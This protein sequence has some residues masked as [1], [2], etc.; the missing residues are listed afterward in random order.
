MEDEIAWEAID[1]T[2]AIAIW[3][4]KYIAK[5]KLPVSEDETYPS[6][7]HHMIRL[8]SILDS[9]DYLVLRSPILSDNDRPRD[10]LTP[11]PRGGPQPHK[12]NMYGL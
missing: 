3:I 2:Y 5:H 10:K 6:F 1:H 11:Y 8:N 7:K 9:L 4:M 12:Q